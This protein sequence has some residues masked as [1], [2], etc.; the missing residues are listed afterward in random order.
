MSNTGDKITVRGIGSYG[1]NW[2]KTSGLVNVAD[3]KGDNRE[4][5]MEQLYAW[6]PDIIYIFRGKPADAY[7]QGK[8]YGQDWS[9]IKAVQNRAVYD[10]PR[11]LMNWGAPNAESPLTLLWMLSKNYPELLSDA[12]F[13]EMMVAFYAR[14]YGIRLSNK[15][16]DEILY[17][18]G[19]Y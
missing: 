14:R 8:I 13:S 16:I 18:H 17:P 11:G 15:L 12:A 4:V 3:I 19:T 7:L 10:M 5:S 2:L 1:D 6:N 9:H